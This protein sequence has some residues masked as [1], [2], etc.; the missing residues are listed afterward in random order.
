MNLYRNSQAI[1]YSVLNFPV[2]KDWVIDPILA[3]MI[4]VL[5]GLKCIM[6]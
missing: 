6:I 2:E 5:Y 1:Y 3:P 4:E